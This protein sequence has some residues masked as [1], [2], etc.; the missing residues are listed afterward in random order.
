METITATHTRLVAVLA[1]AAPIAEL[2]GNGQ[3][4]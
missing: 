3:W 2:L 4:H 1:L